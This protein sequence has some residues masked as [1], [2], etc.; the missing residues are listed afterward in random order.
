MT[1]LSIPSAMLRPVL[2]R[3]VLLLGLAFLL[4]PAVAAPVEPVPPLIPAPQDAAWTAG[5]FDA[6]QYRLSA[7]PAAATA[8]A[9]LQEILGPPTPGP[10]LIQFQSADTN[11]PP[12][13]YTLDIA[14]DRITITAPQPAGFFYAVQTLR[15]LLPPGHSTRLVPAGHIHDWPAFSLRG[16]M[17]DT[18][19]N[20]QT[21]DSLKQQLEIFAHYK[22]NVFHWHLT[23]NPAW[24]IESHAFPQLNDPKFQTRDPGGIYTY[25]Q[26]R[27]LIAFAR[28]RHIIVLPELDMPGHSACFQ[29]ALGYSMG[30]PQGMDALEKIIDEFCDEIPAADRPYLHLGSDEVHIKNPTQFM[31]RMLQA[32]RRHGSQPVIWNPGLKAD[33]Q[34]VVQ[35]WRE[36]PAAAAAIPHNIPYLDSGA[37][38][39]NN[40]DPLLLVQRYFFHQ[41]CF[42]PQGNHQALGGILCCWPDVRVADKVNILR[43]N[44]VWPGLLTFAESFWHGQA[45]DQPQYLSVLPPVASEPLIRYREFEDRLA[46]HRDTFFA[47]QPFPFVKSARIPWRI[48]GPFLR[49]TNQPGD[50][51]FPPEQAIADHYPS[52][53]GTNALSWHEVNGGTILLS[54]HLKQSATGT[55]YALTWIHTDTPRTIHAW[56]GFEAPHRSNRQCGGIPLAG[57]WDSFGGTLLVNQT[58]VPGPVWQQP[59]QN[60]HLQATWFTPANE[61]PYT[62]EEFY[63]TRP[64][65]EVPLRAGWNQILIRVPC[66]YAG[67]SWT[68]T[69]VPVK[70]APNA[71]RWI[72]DES[73]EFSLNPPLAP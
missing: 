5:N 48:I 25:A 29:H 18:G 31:T 32:V 45:Q 68:F 41:P 71:Q 64:P 21:L 20:F 61:V 72:E 38:Y 67:Q 19:R 60:R 33:D 69:F 16:F 28:A 4:L 49:A 70:P 35:L 8:T 26:I 3:V 37:G 58:P 55:A 53:R 63:W 6:T 10:H 2:V 40:Y 7:P 1:A 11:L 42:L 57:Q 14:S 62:D 27:D 50:F 13:S 30:S 54:D 36:G 12:E 47:G 52:A 24:R 43:Q 44:T 39:L 56:F 34:T 51:P 66:G 9:A 46:Y 17:H 22:I 65:A 73:L 23:D 15:Q 59:G